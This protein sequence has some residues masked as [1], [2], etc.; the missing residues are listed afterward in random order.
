ML[1]SLPSL[2]PQVV[3]VGDGVTDLEA[4]QVSGG[5]D[6]FV[7]FGGVVARPAVMQGADWFVT[8]FKTLSDA[9]PRPRIAMIGS[10]EGSA[11]LW[12][13]VSILK[14][15]AGSDCKGAASPLVNPSECGRLAWFA[16]ACARC[17]SPPTGAWACAAVRMIAENVSSPEKA[18]KY[19]QGVR[20]YV[21]EEEV[22]GR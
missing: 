7:G 11:G 17:D 18:D 9:L 4:V 19:H 5:A 12:L 2:A 6:V 10:G 20:M 15:A 16:E 3:M 1:L 14:A 8:D 22:E 13:T 21:H